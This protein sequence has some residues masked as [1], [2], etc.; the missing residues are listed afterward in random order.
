MRIVLACIRPFLRLK[1]LRWSNSRSFVT[2]LV[3]EK[4]LKLAC[5]DWTGNCSWA[6]SFCCT[7]FILLPC[8]KALCVLWDMCLWCKKLAWS[9]SSV[10]KTPVGDVVLRGPHIAGMA[11]WIMILLTPWCKGFRIS[12]WVAVWNASCPEPQH[13]VTLQRATSMEDQNA[14]VVTLEAFSGL[15]QLT[16]LTLKLEPKERIRLRRFWPDVELSQ[17]L[18]GELALRIVSL[19][20]I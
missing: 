19:L 20:L 9:L 1:T 6:L 5:Y 16:E 4:P 13:L 8:V 14:Q 18:A 17:R 2:D 15:L 11:V 10:F 12:M 7:L 3:I